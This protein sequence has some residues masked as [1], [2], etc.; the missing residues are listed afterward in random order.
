MNQLTAELA[1]IK[2]GSVDIVSEANL[3][4]KFINLAH[5]ISKIMQFKDDAKLI[6][7]A[8]VP[9]SKFLGE[10]VPKIID[11]VQNAL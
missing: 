7:M 4:A 9:L 10:E 11:A 8:L 1:S 6:L 5:K 3:K 2:D